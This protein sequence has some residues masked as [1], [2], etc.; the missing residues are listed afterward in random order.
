[1]LAFNVKSTQSSLRSQNC[2]DSRSVSRSTLS[3][4]PTNNMAKSGSCVAMSL[5]S[6]LD[7]LKDSNELEFVGLTDLEV[8][9]NGDR[10]QDW[11]AEHWP[12]VEVKI[13]MYETDRDENGYFG[14]E[15]EQ[16]S[17]RTR[18]YIF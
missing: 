10:G 12:D 18:M 16:S 15:I 2:G 3:L 7:L 14:D 4:V 6:G 9:V 1:M 11:F 13:P 8:Y 5:D 17:G